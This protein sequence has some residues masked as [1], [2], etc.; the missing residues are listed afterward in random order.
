MKK[1]LT[2]ILCL[3]FAFFGCWKTKSEAGAIHTFP[4][5]KTLLC[6]PSARTGLDIGEIAMY[7]GDS[8]EA[9]KS[10]LTRAGFKLDEEQCDGKLCNG[11][12][13]KRSALK[14]KKR[15]PE[16]KIHLRKLIGDVQFQIF[17]DSRGEIWTI[18]WESNMADDCSPPKLFISK[19]RCESFKE[20]LK[21]N[22]GR[23][24]YGGAESIMY[25]SPIDKLALSAEFSEFAVGDKDFY[26]CSAAV[27]NIDENNKFFPFL[28]DELKELYK[29]EK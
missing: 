8:Y 7:I 10:S 26:F 2:I 22:R 27:S 11:F 9:T 20:N 4:Q 17:S 28:P 16:F 19:D 14:E 24:Y 12:F 18:L 23:K 5:A 21:L 3:L 15:D 29:R 1:T 25:F 6:E 13:S